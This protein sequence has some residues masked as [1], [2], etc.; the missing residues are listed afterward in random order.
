MRHFLL[1]IMLFLG[2][3]ANAM[4]QSLD[5]TLLHINDVYEISAKRGAGGFPQL[6]TL[7]KGERAK[8][9]HHLTTF[10][11]D[12]ISPSVMSGLTKGTQMIA[13]MNAVGVDVAGLGNHEFDFGD[14]ILKQRML[15]SNFTWLASNTQG[16][17]DKPFGGARAVMIRQIGELKIGLF[18]LLTT[19]TMHLSSPGRGVSF[20]PPQEAARTAVA[21]LKTKGADLIIA[22]T[23]LDIAEDRALATEVKGIDVILGGHDHDPISFY[24]GGTLIMKAGYDAHYLAVADLHI[25]KKKTKRGIRVSMRPQ[26]RL[27]STAGVSPDGAVAETVKQFEADLDGELSATLG[28]TSVVLDS[29]R[30]TV[31]ARESNMGNLIADAMRQATGADVALTNGGGIRGNRTYEAG[32]T[33]SRKDILS[34]LPFGNVTVVMSLSG[35]DLWAALENAVARVEDKAGRFAQI[36]G[37]AFVYDPAKPKGSRVVSVTVG[38]KP[39]DRTVSYTVATNDYIARGGDAYEVL[40]QGKLVVDAAGATLMA[41]Q[42][43]DYISSLGAIAPVVEGRTRAK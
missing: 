36:S 8:A 11:G 4:A 23:H 25:E 14:D 40:K 6:M 21:A 28:K 39:L 12:L 26:W 18:S 20:T 3:S 30:A 13:L 37:M 1:S 5:L 33:L 19:E 17:D 32:A 10:G 41:S 42:V 43:M 22:I 2:L 15:A 16:A 27:L 7:L 35:A 9:R 24:E 34:E 31:R 38:G 29:R